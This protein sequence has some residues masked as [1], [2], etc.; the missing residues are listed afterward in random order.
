MSLS[1]AVP[2]VLVGAGKM[3]A[4]LARGW[5]AGG[6]PADGLTLVEPA[7][8]PELDAF[9]SSHGIAFTAQP[10]PAPARVM[11][12]AV[13]PQAIGKVM[14]A[15]RTAV[16]PDTLIVSIAAGVRVETLAEGLGSERVVRT[17]PNTPAQVGKGI[18]GA[19]AAPA[20]T[21]ADRAIAEALL[22]AVG[23]AVWVGAETDLDIV[24]ALSGSGP[25]Y[26]FHLVE[27]MAAAGVAEG[28]EAATAMHLARQTVIGAA[29]LM[30]ADMSE[31]AQLRA[32]VT[33]PGGTTEAAL[34]VLMAEDGLG[35]MMRRAIA[36]AR[37]R[38]EE[39]GA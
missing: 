24:T 39:L 23:E 14:G 36:A 35:A 30:E 20:A 5:I 33:S 17:M 10:P 34:K 6:L 26:V 31:A 15:A 18:T 38:G 3:G 2:L 22:A 21:Q 4:A 25:A 32:N 13:K 29:A 12:I 37:Q 7:P 9:A 27:A 16:G 11:V 28:L 1:D 19:F 8:A